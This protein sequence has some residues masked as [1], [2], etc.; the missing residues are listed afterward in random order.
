[1]RPGGGEGRGRAW[2]G[3]AARPVGSWRWGELHPEAHIGRCVI[4]DLAYE[5][6]VWQHGRRMLE[7]CELLEGWHPAAQLGEIGIFGRPAMST[8]RGDP[9]RPLTGLPCGRRGGP[10]SSPPREE[11]QPP[12]Y[13]MRLMHSVPDGDAHTHATDAQRARWRRTHTCD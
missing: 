2:Q 9:G 7:E 1:M 8:V 3:R 6:H 10:P 4:V 11:M 12:R 13:R 5:R